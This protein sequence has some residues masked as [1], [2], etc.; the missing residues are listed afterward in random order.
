VA[1][2]S[3]LVKDPDE[4]T[5]TPDLKKL[6]QQ[7]YGAT[8][9]DGVID[10]FAGLS[11]AWIGTAWI[12]LPG[13]AGLAGVLPAVF[14]STLLVARKRFVEA[15]A[16][17]VKFAEPRRRWE[18][19]NYLATLIG[20]A[21]LLSLGVGV[22]LAVTSGNG[23][24]NWSVGPG[25]L[26]WLLALIAMVLGFLVAAPRMF[27]YAAVLAVAGVF[28]AMADAG[29]GW[30]LLVSG[31]VVLSVGSVM[32]KRFVGRYPRVETL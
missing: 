31:L 17:Y 24:I 4:M 13:F 26:A 8:Y 15:R 6:E 30:P 14:V 3:A 32:L 10:I 2:Y 19:R 5:D 20:G 16:G 12:W 18:R 27:G 21:T 1:K 7:A 23:D 29:P 22:F 11:L 25:L 28:A 9:S